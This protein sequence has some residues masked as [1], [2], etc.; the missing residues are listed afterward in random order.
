MAAPGQYLNSYTADGGGS[1]ISA[2]TAAFN[3]N[4]GIYGIDAYA[5]NWN[6]GSIQL[7]KLSADKTHYVNVGSAITASGYTAPVYLEAGTYKIGVTTVTGV[8]AH[9]GRVTSAR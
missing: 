2:D 6:S 3:L 1:G 4:A 7:E 8:F 5:S 9:I